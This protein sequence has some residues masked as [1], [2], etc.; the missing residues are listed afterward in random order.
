MFEIIFLIFLSFLFLCWGSFLNVVA[1]RIVSDLPFLRKRSHCPKCDYQIA[2][3]DN[4]PILSWILLRAKCRKC[5]TRISILYPFI[6]LLTLILML[7]LTIHTINL[8]LSY[9]QNV[10][11]FISYF[12]FFTALIVATRTDL[13]AMVIPQL[14]SL[15][16][17]PVALTFSYLGFL[18][19]NFYQSLIGAI[20]GYFILWI[21][22]TLFK[23]FTKKEG[24]GVGDMELLCMIGAFL[25]PVAVWFSLL[26]ASL[27]GTLIGAIYLYFFAK[28]KRAKIPFGPFLALGSVL[29]FFF[30]SFLFYFARIP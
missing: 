6:E 1:F 17:V 26:I 3:Y 11:Y 13:Q 10:F 14:F 27:T 30:E 12:I 2:F 19:L 7:G 4:I 15:W 16:L 25:G 20:F 21:I 9:P 5:K 18:K 23:F 24:L 28:N 29:F 22:A 8:N